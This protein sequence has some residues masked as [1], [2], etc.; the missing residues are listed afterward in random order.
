MK[1]KTITSERWADIFPLVRVNYQN[2]TVTDDRRMSEQM[3][4]YCPRSMDRR[5]EV[6]KCR[7]IFL[8]L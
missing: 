7:R 5:P 2:E 1:Y 3:H 4:L 8:Y 6:L